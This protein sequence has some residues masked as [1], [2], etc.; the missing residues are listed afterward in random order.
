M[1][2]TSWQL[3]GEKQW[4]IFLGSKITESGDYSHEI[5]RHLLLGG[6]AMT[7]LDRELDH[8]EDWAPKN[9]CFWTVVLEKTL[10]RPLVS[11]DIK[12]VNPQGNQPWIVIGRTD[13]EAEALILWPPDVKCQLI[14][15]NL[16][17]GKDRSKKRRG[18][19]GMRR[20]ASLT[21]WTWIW[22][23]SKR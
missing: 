9:W 3:E 14:G 1:A 11:K 19:Q 15:K 8:K 10:E 7:N 12:P 22:A 18:K 20:L 5:K 4:Q 6:K 13:A 2:K 16:D 23:N 17:A 21:Q